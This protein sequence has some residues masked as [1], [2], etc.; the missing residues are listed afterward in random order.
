[1]TYGEFDMTAS[2]SHECEE[3]ALTITIQRPPR[4]LS[5]TT[6]RKAC[7]HLGAELRRQVLWEAECEAGRAYWNALIKR[8]EEGLPKR[9]RE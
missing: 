1:M 6:G 8:C 9:K 3:C 5:G 7:R 2:I 4:P